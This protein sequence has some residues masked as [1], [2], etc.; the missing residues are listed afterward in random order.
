MRRSS[1]PCASLLALV[2]CG[3]GGDDAP[4]GDG[5]TGGAVELRTSFTRTTTTAATQLTFD[6]DAAIQPGDQLIAVVQAKTLDDIELAA[7]PGWTVLVEDSAVM[8]INPFH[9][10]LL[11]TTASA[12]TAFDFTFT[13]AD[14][15]SAIVTAYAGGST[16]R[17]M[18]WKLMGTLRNLPIT[19]AAASLAAGAVVWMGGGGQTNWTSFDTPVGTAQLE[20]IDNVAAFQRPAPDGAVPAIE[21]PNDNG[22]CANVGQIS[23]EP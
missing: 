11:V 22:F 8:C 18:D 7:N 17:L 1:T 3:G 21:L 14:T 13:T 15:F 23:V 19:Y 4:A 12:N 5:P 20:L 9:V 16:P 2:A 6:G 10:W